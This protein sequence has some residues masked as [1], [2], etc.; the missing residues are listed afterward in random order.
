MKFLFTKKVDKSLLYERMSIPGK[1]Q[2]EL[3]QNMLMH[4]EYRETKKISIKID[5]TLYE[6][7][8]V[9]QKYNKKKYPS[10]V[11]FI[12][13]LYGKNDRL[14]QKLRSVFVTSDFYLK[15]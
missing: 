4:L 2:E 11:P 6:A 12:K 8:I 3:L 14:K 13:I 1:Y 5:D 10:H 15:Q 7:T 9:N